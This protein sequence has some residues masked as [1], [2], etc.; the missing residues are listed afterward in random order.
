MF[1]HY[2][3]LYSSEYVSV[4][5]STLPHVVHHISPDELP[6]ASFMAYP[7]PG[8]PLFLFHRFS[9]LSFAIII[10]SPYPNFFNLFSLVF[11]TLFISSKLILTQKNHTTNVAIVT[12]ATNIFI[13]ATFIFVFHLSYLTP[14]TH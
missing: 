11:S 3:T 14:T 2:I 10:S 6:S 13:S 5:S 4:S 12:N 8:F 7:F 9:W 1:E